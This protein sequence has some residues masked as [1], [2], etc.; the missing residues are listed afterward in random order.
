MKPHTRILYSIWCGIFAAEVLVAT[1]FILLNTII[2][3]THIMM[4]NRSD[5]WRESIGSIISMLTPTMFGTLLLFGCVATTM[6]HFIKY[7][8]TMR[9]LKGR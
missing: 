1:Q 2:T 9:E 7:I 5:A 4:M 6:Y 3:P 8:D